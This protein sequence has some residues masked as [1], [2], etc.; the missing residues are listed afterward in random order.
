MSNEQRVEEIIMLEVTQEPRHSTSSSESNH[1]RRTSL[2]AHCLLLIAS[3]CGFVTVFGLAHLLLIHITKPSGYVFFGTLATV[4]LIIAALLYGF[5][6]ERRAVLTRFGFGA[7]LCV[8]AIPFIYLARF[9]PES[10]RP[11][12]R[13]LL[14][15]PFFIV[16]LIGP[17]VFVR[18]RHQ[19]E[20]V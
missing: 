8:C 13:N 5:V 2:V 11:T 4:P 10:A 6:S 12:V 17:G 9:A 18:A 7:L 19:K 20:P 15:L 3:L 14:G 1:S 16:A